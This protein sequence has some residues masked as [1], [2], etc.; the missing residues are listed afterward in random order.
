LPS[1]VGGGQKLHAATERKEAIYS[2]VAVT[3]RF[4]QV[5]CSLFAVH[6]VINFVWV[7]KEGQITE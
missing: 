3:P 5:L 4:V 1:V 6:C 7:E 2:G